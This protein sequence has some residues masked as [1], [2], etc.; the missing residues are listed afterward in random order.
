MGQVFAKVPVSERSL[1]V[2]RRVSPSPNKSLNSIQRQLG[3]PIFIRI[4]KRTRELEIWVKDADCFR[5]C[6]LRL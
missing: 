2:V 4:F 3:A 6:P 5:K 1:E